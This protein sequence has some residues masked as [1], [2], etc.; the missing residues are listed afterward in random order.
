MPKKKSKHESAIDKIT[1][2]LVKQG[3]K[4]RWAPFLKW[5]G[6]NEES[7]ERLTRLLVLH[8]MLDRAITALITA[9]F[10]RLPGSFF[11]VEATVAKLP[12][13]QRIN[14]LRSAQFIT[15]PCAKDLHAVNEVR[16][17]LAHYQ[18][19]LGFEMSTV[20][21]L[22]SEKAFEQCAEKGMRALNEISNLITA[23]M[24]KEQGTTSTPGPV[25][26]CVGQGGLY[27]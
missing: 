26:E 3:E 4:A 20:K 1:R 18:P 6:L 22:S 11:K 25:S 13:A 5:I 12:I 7:G 19:Q 10:S 8:L 27:S 21:E 16:N 24:A 17:N 14:L 23:N 15:D 2:A 9:R